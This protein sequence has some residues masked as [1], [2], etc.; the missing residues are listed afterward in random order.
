M[1]IRLQVTS[2][3]SQVSCRKL[4][5][6]AFSTRNLQPATFNLHSAFSLIE[7]LVV[8]SLL[9]LIVLGLLA[10]FDR[11]QQA[12]TASMTQTD[13]LQGGRG[14]MDLIASDLEQMTPSFGVSNGAVNFYAAVPANYTP[15][16]NTLPGSVQIR[17]NVLEDLFVLTRQ[18]LSGV[19]SWVGIGYAVDT[20]Q[21]G[22]SPSAPFDPLYRFATNCPVATNPVSLFNA[23]YNAVVFSDSITNSGSHLMDGVVDLRARAY[24]ANGVWMTNT[25][26]FYANQTT[27]NPNVQ[28]P[29]PAWGETG[30]YM[31]SNMLPATVEVELGVLE[32]GA[33]Q[34]AES[35]LTPTNYLAQQA[36]RVHLFR[37]RVL[38]RNLDPAAYQ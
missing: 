10:V 37:R 2:C 31:Y 8:S 15:L 35:L 12:F 24:D 3:R 36:G 33:L 34:R 23:F 9:I 32:A 28:F 11:T 38:I 1:K 6:R 30:F 29:P 26:A 19:D 14:A 7:V 18:N 27:T 22:V 4:E 5:A 17:T 13:V 25:Y 16:T 20:S 21:N